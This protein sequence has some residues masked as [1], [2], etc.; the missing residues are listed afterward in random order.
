MPATG[1]ASHF[2]PPPPK[3]RSF[4]RPFWRWL[5]INSRFQ[6]IFK[7]QQKESLFLKSFAGFFRRRCIADTNKR[8]RNEAPL[9]PKEN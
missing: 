9:K 2:T 7:R 5:L 3:T 1:T 4:F 6:A 8:R